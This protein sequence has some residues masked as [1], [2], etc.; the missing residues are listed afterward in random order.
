[1]DADHVLTPWDGVFFELERSP[2]D[3]SSP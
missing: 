3:G 2:G 1:V